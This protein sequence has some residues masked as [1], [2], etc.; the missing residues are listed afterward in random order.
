MQ[1]YIKFYDESVRWL[2]I[3]LSVLFVPAFLYRLFHVILE[4]ANDAS[5]I[6]Y[7]VFEVLPILGTIVL[8]VDIVFCALNRNIPLNLAEALNGGTKQTV[9]AEVIDEPK[10]G[11]KN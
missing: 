1:E 9:E 3:V 8:V 4:K 2:R 10:D 11:E 6:V 5:K 7:M